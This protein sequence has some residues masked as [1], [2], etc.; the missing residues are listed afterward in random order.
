MSGFTKK[1]W[2]ARTPKEV[3]DFI[4]ASDNAPKIVSS[5]KSMVKLT[6][7][8]LRVGTKYLETRV[9]NGKDHQTELEVIEYVPDQ[10]YTMKNF[11]EGIEIIYQYVFTP[12]NNGTQIDLVCAL[13]ASG[14]KKLML[15]I[16]SSIF[17]KEDGDHLQR[18]KKAME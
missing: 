2:I 1:E 9:M 13:K 4:T 8:P 3:F 12:E 16:V 15:P 17:Q 5:V 14:L 6:D 10:I 7:G 11:T 18:L